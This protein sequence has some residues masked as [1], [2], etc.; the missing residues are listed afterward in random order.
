MSY[1]S[2]RFEKD[3]L[4]SVPTTRVVVRNLDNGQVPP[5]PSATYFPTYPDNLQ[6][7]IVAEWITDLLG[8]GFL[9]AATLAD[10]TTYAYKPL[11][12]IEDLSGNFALTQVGD[13]IEVFLDDPTLWTSEE[14]P[15]SNFVFTVASLIDANNIT[16]SP[17]LPAFLKDFSWETRRLIGVS[18]VVQVQG[19][20]GITRRPG[21]NYG[22]PPETFLEKRFNAYFTTAVDAQNFVE[23]TK[24]EMTALSNELL[25]ASIVSESYTASPTI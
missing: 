10:L 1:V 19:S 17:E 11:T 21:V 15:G 3:S 6:S 24:A 13:L 12:Q 25:G 4:I 23:A 18:Y 22:S 20:L 5:L 8:E 9:N 7:F 16:V 14:Y 2:A